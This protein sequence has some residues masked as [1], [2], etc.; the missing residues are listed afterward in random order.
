MSSQNVQEN[1]W[2]EMH[3][4]ACKSPETE[5]NLVFFIIFMI[6]GCKVHG[7]LLIIK[8]Y[9]V[10]QQKFVNCIINYRTYIIRSHY[11]RNMKKHIVHL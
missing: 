7:N 8:Q 9:R 10:V 6:S 4:P 2:M 11:Y 3:E 1:Q 5:A